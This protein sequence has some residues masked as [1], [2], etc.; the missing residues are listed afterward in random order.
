MLVFKRAPDLFKTR[1][2]GTCKH[3][4][5]RIGFKPMHFQCWCLASFMIFASYS[6]V[7]A[8]DNVYSFYSV[9]DYTWMD[10]LTFPWSKKRI[11]IV[12]Y[13]CISGI[14]LAWSIYIV[15]AISLLKHVSTVFR[16]CS[17]P[18]LEIDRISRESEG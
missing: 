9:Y 1:N 4:P 6:G 10:D 11:E 2:H 14:G 16:N 5:S 17:K 12:F 15:I 18:Y 7:L 8:T 13:Y 3:I